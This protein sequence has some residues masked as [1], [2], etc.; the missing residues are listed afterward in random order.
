MSQTAV[1]LFDN[2]GAAD[3]VL[4]DLDASEFPRK[5]IR[6][7]REPIDMPVTGVMSTPRID[8]E[9]G[10]ERDLRAIG[11][12]IGQANAYAQGVRRGGILV[13]ATG[14]NA[15]VDIASEIM[16]R[17]G[18]IEVRELTGAEPNLPGPATGSDLPSAEG[19]SQTG[20]VRQAD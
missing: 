1:G 7:L 18:A 15:E 16:N 12:T 3:D 10:L 8:F 9:A 20:R 6:V 5:E 4:L 19:P 14:S 13:F 2:A 11:A 17:H